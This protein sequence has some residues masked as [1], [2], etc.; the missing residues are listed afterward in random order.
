MH[1]CRCSPSITSKAHALTARPDR[2]RAVPLS[3]AAGLRRPLPAAGGAKASGAIE[4]LGTT[5]DDALGEAFDKTAKLLGLGYP[6]GP[7]VETA[8]ERATPTASPCRGRCWAARTAFFLLGPEDGGAA[9]RRSASRR[10]REQDVADLCAGFQAAVA[11]V[12]DRT[13]RAMAR[14]RAE[15]WA[16]PG[17]PLVVAGGVAANAPAGRPWRAS[18]GRAGDALLV[19]PPAL[20][21][22][23]GAMIAWAGAERLAPRPDRPPRLPGPPPLAARPVRRPD[24]G[25]GKHGAKA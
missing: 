24:L 25:A 18:R 11:E 22:D 5:I 19:P 10:S 2:R 8:A 3:A 15:R 23:N 1:G 14:S 17:P 6:G 20:C 16:E 9:S 4:R 12:G 7:A 21:T 13:R